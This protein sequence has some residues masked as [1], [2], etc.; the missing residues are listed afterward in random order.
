MHFYARVMFLYCSL[1]FT[2]YLWITT[3]SAQCPSFEYW[4]ANVQKLIWRMSHGLIT[5]Y[6]RLVF[7]AL[8]FMEVD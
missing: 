7:L 4:L 8:M 2:I 1:F 5:Y 3:Q 6:T